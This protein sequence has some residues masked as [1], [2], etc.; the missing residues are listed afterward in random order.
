MA[1][2]LKRA[3]VCILTIGLTYLISVAAGIVMV[4]SGNKFA[5][6]YRDQLVAQASVSDPAARAIGRGEKVRAALLDFSRNLLL[7]AVPGTIS[8]MGIVPPYP[9]AA[10]RGWVGGIVSVDGNR[11]SRLMERSARNY[12]LVVL[13]LQLLPYSLTG[14]AGVYMGLAWYRHWRASGFRWSWK[15]LL[16]PGALLDVIWIYTLAIPLF[17]FASVIEFLM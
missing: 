15:A 13:I 7:G 17:L 12:Y 10:F 4:S 2:A 5:L 6:S 16:P 14:G 3:R 1:S 11:R 8:G 9:I